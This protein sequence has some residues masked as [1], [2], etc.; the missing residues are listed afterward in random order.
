MGNKKQLECLFFRYQSIQLFLE[1]HLGLCAQETRHF[2]L[3]DYV[4]DFRSTHLNNKDASG[5]PPKGLDCFDSI[6][7]VSTTLPFLAQNSDAS[8]YAFFCNVLEFVK[9]VSPVC[10]T[11]YESEPS[12]ITPELEVQAVK[13]KKLINNKFF[14]L[15]PLHF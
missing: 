14:N 2:R 9:P 3:P 4:S 13:T 8:L 15:L 5:Q 6:F 1:Q 10:A 7:I 12:G 11:L